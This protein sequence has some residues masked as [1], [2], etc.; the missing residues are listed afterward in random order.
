MLAV[1]NGAAKSGSTWLYNIVDRLF[2]FE[3]PAGEY[4][5]SSE[6]H[7]TI[8][9]DALE[10][11]LETEDF[12]SRN[13]ITK[14]HYG[15][16]RLRDLLLSHPCT[17]VLDMTRGLND[18]IVS[19]YYDAC[20][21]DGFVGSFEKFYWFEGRTLAEYLIRY[22]ELW[23]DRHP[24]VLVTSFE[25]LK[26]DFEREAWRIADFLGARV[27]EEAVETLKHE[28]SMSNMREQYSDDPQYADA[29]NPFFRKGMIG[30][31]RNHFNDRMLNDIAAIEKSG[32]RKLD[33]IELSNK[34]KRKLYSFFPS[35]APYQNAEAKK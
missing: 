30:D 32:I 14:N 22:H 7:P 10:E 26:K 29:Q 4:L 23:G 2:E 34:A 19:S 35:L 20:R 31:W 16:K 8:R 18:V 25:A 27:S 6:K 12:T 17:R 28:T 13:F 11:F 15:N 3:W 21:R 5:T 1:C 33:P 24:Q 9:P